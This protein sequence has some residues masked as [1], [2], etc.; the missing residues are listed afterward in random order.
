MYYASQHALFVCKA[1]FNIIVLALVKSYLG[2]YKSIR[3]YVTIIYGSNCP[4]PVDNHL[5]VVY[6]RV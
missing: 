5:S 3:R 1:P 6:L 2:H 4:I